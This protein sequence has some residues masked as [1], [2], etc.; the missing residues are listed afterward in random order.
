MANGRC[1][2]HG[3]KSTGAKTPQVAEINP[4]YKYGI[5]GKY[6][7]DE[8]KT[9]IDGNAFKA[10]QVEAELIAVRVRLKRTLEARAA[11]E[12]S[13]VKTET[14]PKPD[15]QSELVL[16]GIEEGEKPFGKDADVMPFEARTFKLPDF[17]AIIE[18]CLQ[19][20]ESLEKTR[21][22]LL[23]DDDGDNP[24]PGRDR[25]TFSGGLNGGDDE[26]LPSPFAP[27]TEP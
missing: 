11:W 1:K 26:E 12:A 7:N 22:E 14:S 27:K 21:K 23:K 25:V 17:D 3:G 4:A 9:L 2:R 8:E 5:Y 15:G 16:V 18:R 10:G 24:E 20:I 13:L 6:Y 19:R